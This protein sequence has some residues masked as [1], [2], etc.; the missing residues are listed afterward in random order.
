MMKLGILSV[1][2]ILAIVFASA[3]IGG[4]ATASSSEPSYSNNNFVPHEVIV[5]FKERVSIQDQD[6]IIQKHGGT[7]IKGNDALNSVLILVEEEQAFINEITKDPTVKYAERNGFVHAISLP[8]NQRKE[9]LDGFKEGVWMPYQDVLIPEHGRDITK[10]NEASFAPRE[11]TEEPPTTTPNDPKWDEQWG[12]QS[13]KCPEVWRMEKGS[14]CVLLAIVDTGIDYNHEDL[15][16]YVAGGYDFVNNDNDPWDDHYLGHGTHC[17]GIAAA[18]MDNSIGIAGVAQV[19]VMAEK[20]LNAF[21]SGT[22]FDGALGVTHATDFGADVISMSFGSSGYSAEMANACQ[23]AW[24]AGVILAGAA[25]NS[26][27]TPVSYPARYDTVI[28]VGSIGKT[29]IVS[30]FSQYGAEMELVAPG[31][32][33]LSTTPGDRYASLG[34]TSMATPHVAGVAAL[35][36][37]HFPSWTN[38]DV[39]MI[40]QDT[41]KDLGPTGWDEHYGYGKVNPREDAN[42]VGW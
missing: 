13:I 1:I 39:R 28:C 26:G 22:V 40:L 21:G 24:D 37:S 35:I 2:S 3:S 11:N 4:I 42:H 12:P 9:V 18:T 14:L 41:A 5:S 17:A 19:G 7:I 27:G 30:G 6:G 16:H 8:Y 15:T 36:I 38:S 31:E 29:D 34:G 25:G 23:Y 10:R 33:I 20:V 32:S